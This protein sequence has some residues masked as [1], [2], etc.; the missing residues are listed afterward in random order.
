MLLITPLRD[1]STINDFIIKPQR[2]GYHKHRVKP[3]VKPC[4]LTNSPNG[5]KSLLCKIR[6]NVFPNG[7]RLLPFHADYHMEDGR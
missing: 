6:K 1:F 4:L 7:N 2:G 5:A 3:C